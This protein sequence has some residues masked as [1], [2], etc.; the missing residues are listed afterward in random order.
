MNSRVKKLGVPET[1]TPR[2]S[3]DCL[4]LRPSRLFFAV[5]AFCIT[6]VI[7]SNL[8][9]LVETFPLPQG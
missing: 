2:Q 1:A 9:S 5:Q 3:R 4:S 8:R 7:S 6:S